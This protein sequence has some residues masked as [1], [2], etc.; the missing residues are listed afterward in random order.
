VFPVSDLGSFANG[1][2]HLVVVLPD[3]PSTA[4]LVDR[5]VIDRLAPGATL[6][7]VGRGGTVD[8][9][10]VVAALRSGRLSRAVLD[11]LPIEPLPSSDK[12]WDEPGLVITSHTSAWSRPS[13]V[14]LFF[15]DN[16]Q[17]F[18][19]GQPLKGRVDVERGY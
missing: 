10:S 16:L 9:E 13:D 12:L 1:L 18:R 11:V 2:D 14:V 4:G 19:S 3:T 17:R 5:S 8:V 7:N 6:I 15:E